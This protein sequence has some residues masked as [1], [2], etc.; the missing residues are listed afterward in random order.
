VQELC[1][2][3][4]KLSAAFPAKNARGVQ[5]LRTV[6]SHHGHGCTAAVSVAQNHRGFRLSE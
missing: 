3:Y 2:R 4:A 1:L 5:A 6:S